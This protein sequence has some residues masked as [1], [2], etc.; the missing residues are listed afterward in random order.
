MTIPTISK[1]QSDSGAP[2]ASDNRL[3]PNSVKANAIW[4]G[5]PCSEKQKRQA[6]AA[7]LGVVAFL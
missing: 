5:L 3:Q 4:S 2:R 6:F 1:D 7:F